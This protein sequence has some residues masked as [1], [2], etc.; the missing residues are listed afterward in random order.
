MVTTPDGSPVAMVHCN[1]CTSDLNAWVNLF[2]EF[3]GKW[4]MK[5]DKN[6]LYGRL[7]R[8][9]LSADAD[10]GGLMAY[11]YLSGEPVTGLEEGRPMFVRMPD[12]PWQ[13]S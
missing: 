8:E 10:C 12:L 3:A 5:P 6:E 13:I 9:A 11:N 2:E 4:G 1:N 7:Y